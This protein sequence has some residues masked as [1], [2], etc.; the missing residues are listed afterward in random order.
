MHDGRKIFSS[1]WLYVQN[2]ENPPNANNDTPK[3]LK[4]KHL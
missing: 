3:T 2:D 4:R 1:K